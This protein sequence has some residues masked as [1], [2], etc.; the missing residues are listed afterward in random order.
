[1]ETIAPI[2]CLIGLVATIIIGVAFV[3]RT[4]KLITWRWANWRVLLIAIVLFGTGLMNLDNL[5]YRHNTLVTS[6]TN[7]H[8][9]PKWPLR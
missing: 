5:Q 4:I 1:M 9:D 2:L 8:Y 3:F 7:T 6:Q